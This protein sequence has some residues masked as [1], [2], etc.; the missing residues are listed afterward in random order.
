MMEV[1]CNGASSAVCGAECT[2][3]Q[4]TH[5]LKICICIC[6]CVCICI[7]LLE[8][9]EPSPNVCGAEC[10]AVQT[11]PHLMISLPSAAIFSIIIFIII[12]IFTSYPPLVYTL[13]YSTAVCHL[14]GGVDGT[15]TTP[16]LR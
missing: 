1:Q 11:T 12:I 8:L 15:Q 10:I 5:H 4:T 6:P 7:C 14:V 2:A 9:V 3:V 13:K 16:H